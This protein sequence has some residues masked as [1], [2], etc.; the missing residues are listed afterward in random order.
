MQVSVVTNNSPSFGSLW[1]TR[2]RGLDMQHLERVPQARAGDAPKEDFASPGSGGPD[3]DQHQ[4]GQTPKAATPAFTTQPGKQQQQQ[5]QQTITSSTPAVY[6]LRGVVNHY[7]GLGGGHYTANA[8]N[9]TDNRWYEFSDDR[10]SVVDNEADLVTSAAYVLFYSRREA[11]LNEA[12]EGGGS[13]GDSSS[14]T[15]V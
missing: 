4:E 12:G 11:C 15:C 5:Q 3:V 7:G 14:R 2:N 9:M 8:L 13:E 6:D 1:G 10:V